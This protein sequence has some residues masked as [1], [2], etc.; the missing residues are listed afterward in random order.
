VIPSL[1]SG[2]RHV[3]GSTLGATSDALRRRAGVV[4]R[5][6]RSSWFV[7]PLDGREWT[8]Q[9]LVDDLVD[10]RTEVIG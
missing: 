6:E 1:P 9:V 2:I 5:D 10:V 3:D 4:T 8:A 7:E